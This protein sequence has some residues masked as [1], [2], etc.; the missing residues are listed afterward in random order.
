MDGRGTEGTLW[1]ETCYL[2]WPESSPAL[3]K[4]RLSPST[5]GSCVSRG[6]WKGG[7]LASLGL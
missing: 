6:A 2:L 5:K 7:V 3:G 1:G 4:G